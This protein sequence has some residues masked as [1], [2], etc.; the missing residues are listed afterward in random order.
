MKVF[1]IYDHESAPQALHHKL[2]ITLPAKWL[3][4]S[5]DKVKELFVNAYN[6][7]FPDNQL[8]DEEFVLSV[9][10]ASPFTNRDYKLLTIDDTPEK[11]FT[12]KGEVR[13]VPASMANAAKPGALPNGKLRCK[14]YGCQKEYSEDDNSDHACKHHASNPIFHDTRKWWSCCEG[15][16]VYS[17]EELM[18]IPGC[19]V[20]KH[21]NVP[22]AKEIEREAEIKAA[23]NKV[24][25]M[26]M[27]ASKPVQGR[28]PPPKQEFVP[29][30]V[31]SCCVPK[32]SSGRGRVEVRVH[33]C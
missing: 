26:H 28:A 13:L 33:S 29:R 2:A 19:Q 18:A 21:S 11:C 15:V 14:N 7:K 8:D 25:E 24:L 5:C 22:P 27:A 12:D 4:Q 17:F 23:T 30:Y 31:H 20:G 32:E 16:K 6:K 1:V 3:E 9:K 10:D